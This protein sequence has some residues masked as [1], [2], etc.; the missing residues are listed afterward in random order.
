M[1]Y[2]AHGRVFADLPRAIEH[3]Y[4]LFVR[5]AS[6]DFAMR[7]SGLTTADRGPVPRKIAHMVLARS[8]AIVSLPATPWENYGQYARWLPATRRHGS[9]RL[10]E[11]LRLAGHLAGGSTRVRRGNGLRAVS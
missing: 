10:M 6:P 11:C 8:S 3:G 5:R 7:N 1:I 9:W 4:S 2:R